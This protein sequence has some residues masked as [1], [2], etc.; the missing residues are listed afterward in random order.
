MMILP[1][2]WEA[3]PAAGSEILRR[4]EGF[5]AV[6]KVR[7][8]LS[9]GCRSFLLGAEGVSPTAGWLVANLVLFFVVEA[10]SAGIGKFL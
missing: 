8:A 6:E 7:D 4:A 5:S 2:G 10:W 1:A 9:G 3:V